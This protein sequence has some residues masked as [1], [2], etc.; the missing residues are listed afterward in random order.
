M[1]TELSR[2]AFL[3]SGGALVVGFSFAGAGL[4]ARAAAAAPS[5]YTSDGPL[6]LNQVDSFLAI[7]ADNTATVFSEKVE[8]GQGTTTGTLQ[9]VAE[10]LDLD[11]S[12]LQTAR[13]DSNLFANQGATVASNGIQVGGTQI[14]AA[15]AHARQTLL[16]LA[17]ERLGV[18]ASSLT[19]ARGVVSGGGRSMTYGELLGD[20]RFSVTMSPAT[21]HPGVAPAK[22]VAQYKVVTT[23]IPRVDIPD[24]VAGTNVS[25]HKVHVP[26]MLHGRV[27]RPR[28]QRAWGTGAPVLSIDEGSVKGIPGVQVVRRGDFVGVVAPKE[29]DAVMA[30]LALRVRWKEDTSLPGNGNLFSHMRRQPTTDVLTR[31]TGDLAAGFAG[32]AKT[33]SGSYEIAYQT[34]A[35]QSPSC[36]LADVTPNG[37]LVMCSTQDVFGMRTKLVNVLGRPAQQVRVVYYEGSGCYGQNLHDDVAQAAAIMSQ[38][39]GKPIRVQLMR[40]DEH[41]WG[42]TEAAHIIDVRGGIDAAGRLTAL[43]VTALQH[44]WKSVEPSQQL[45]LGAPYPPTGTSA[46]AGVTARSGGAIYG[47]PSYRLVNRYYNGVGSGSLPGT[48]MRSPVDLAAAF[49]SEQAIDA[50]AY[51]AGMDPVAFRRLNMGADTRWLGVLDAVTQAS[52]WQP[53]PAASRLSKENIVTGRGVGLGSHLTSYGGVVAE[54]EVN[55]KTGKIVVTHTYAALD[56]GLAVNPGLVENQIVGQQMM[57]VS[58]ALFEQLHFGKKGVTSLDWA[59]YPILRFREHPKVTAMVVQRL[60]QP[61]TGAGEESM[62]PAVAAIANAFFDATGV[63]LY[64]QPMAPGY[65]RGALAAAGVA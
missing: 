23:R 24:K 22:P 9:I 31:Q 3:R 60:D 47:S 52:G 20:K 30:S 35:S 12:Q 58:R 8:L 41:G 65:V 37:A 10:E 59:G 56:V 15:A 13:V 28:G 54:I 29:Y 43:D 55:K 7:H 4:A 33:V 27:V 44:G 45:A 53:R 21:L 19:V 39:L 64:R 62:A 5:P 50:L 16:N 61:S 49:A 32:A 18:P 57:A 46:V 11:L 14:R 36:A 63:R 25:M 1:S 42:N 17:S 40:S 48:N 26:G 38:E 34:H 51:A 2:R 6:P